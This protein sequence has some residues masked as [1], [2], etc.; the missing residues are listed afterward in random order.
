[1]KTLTFEK[2]E[3]IEPLVINKDDVVRFTKNENTN[4]LLNGIVTHIISSKDLLRYDS[5]NIRNCINEIINEVICNLKKSYELSFNGLHSIS[6]TDCGDVYVVQMYK[7]SPI[8]VSQEY[9][10]LKEK[11]DELVDSTDVFESLK[12]YS[13]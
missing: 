2:K 13:L 4:I 8:Y 11:F 1:M 10:D 9:E 5:E 3:I 6:I 12:H 7:T